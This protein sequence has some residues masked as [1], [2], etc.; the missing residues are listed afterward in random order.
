V[1]GFYEGPRW[2]RTTC[3]ARIYL[4]SFLGTLSMKADFMRVGEPEPE[5]PLVSIVMPAH[6][7]GETIGYAIDSVRRQ[8]FS[9]WE[10]VIIDDHSTD[11]TAEVAASYGATDDR[12]RY[13]ENSK[14][15]VSSAR[16]FAIELARGELIGFLDAD[17]F[18]YEDALGK[19][20]R[21]LVDNRSVDAVFCPTEM[22]DEASDRLGWVV[23]TRPIVGFPDMHSCPFHINGVM[24][25]RRALKGMR[26]DEDVTNGEDWLLWQRIARTGTNFHIVDTCRVAYRQDKEST[27]H[28]DFLEHEKRIE[29]VISVIY[30]QDPDC[31]MPHEVFKD[32]LRD[33]PKELVFM[34]RRLGTMIRFLL[35]NDEEGALSIARQFHPVVWQQ[36]PASVVAR[37]IQFATMR[38]YV[39]KST[40]WL[41]HWSQHCDTIKPFF[42][43]NFPRGTYPNMGGTLF[44]EIEGSN[45]RRAGPRQS[46]RKALS[47]LVSRVKGRSFRK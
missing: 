34:K 15:G 11:D 2:R 39:C 23:G 18:Y 28:C 27:V 42:E 9:N 21:H 22:V 14:K 12:I 17:D 16:N 24:L 32:G 41:A 3:T 4:F 5:G 33:P 36:L 31:A 38:Y 43:R 8:S 29:K 26:F 40:E 35:S 46:L 44:R 20:V 47:W 10:M 1:A 19:R 6:N 7:A 37:M 30:G 13:V 25:R 45:Q